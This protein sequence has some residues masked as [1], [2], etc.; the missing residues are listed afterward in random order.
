MLSILIGIND[1]LST[2][3]KAETVERYQATYDK[4]LAD[5]I[6]ALPKTKIVLGEPFLL[7]VGKEK[8]TYAAN[9]LELKKR[10]AVVAQLAAK[11]HLPVIHF[12]QAFDDACQK[13]PPDHWSWDGI[14]PT[15]AGHALMAQEW[16][17]TVTAFWPSG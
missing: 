16:L 5:T 2:G 3:E 7:P 6:A 17:R 14:H 11:Y 13:A 4:L 12:Q 15:Y 9:L 1:T 10:Q 8:A